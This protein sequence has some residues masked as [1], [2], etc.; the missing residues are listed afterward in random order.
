MYQAFFRHVLSRIPAEAA[1]TLAFGGLRAAMAVPG[2]MALC[3]RALAP[4]APSLIVRALGLE[5]PG[6]L[7]LAAGFDK[8]ALAPDALGALGFGFVEIGTVTAEPQTGNPKPRLF[9]LPADRALVNRLGFNNRGAAAAAARLAKR[10]GPTIVGVNLGKTKLAPDGEAAQDYAASAR[11]LGPFADYCV[12]NVSSPNTPGLRDLQRTEALRP[13]LSK[14]RDAL[15]RSAPGKCVP[16][17]VKVAPDLAD[18]DLD[19]LAALALELG[20]DG[21]VATNTTILREPLV[22]AAAEV[23]RMGAG[24]L[25]GRPVKTRAL[26]VLRR[27][28]RKVDGRLILVA[29]G[30]IETAEDAL[31]RLDA[32]ATLLQAYTAFVYEG[33]LFAAKLHRDLAS[34]IEARSPPMAPASKAAPRLAR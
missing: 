14:V 22:S 26:E 33:P 25:S 21:I 27:L 5:F 8:D 29:A 2:V 11:M 10:R 24:G 12:V 3:R 15:E 23:E 1:H 13:I 34:L 18:D 20:L 9:R 30:G 16:L 4:R 19:E 7:G 31:A 6:P 32:G 28:A 17:L